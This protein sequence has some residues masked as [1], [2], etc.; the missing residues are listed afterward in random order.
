[1]GEKWIWRQ[2]I[3][4]ESIA[5]IL[6]AVRYTCRLIIPHVESMLTATADLRRCSNQFADMKL[7]TFP[8]SEMLGDTRIFWEGTP[9]IRQPLT[10]RI[11][12]SKDVPFMIGAQ[13]SSE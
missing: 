6:R 3:S 10:Q 8:E 4:E 12:F 13:V 11:T 9:C 2:W 7:V 1:M 5:L